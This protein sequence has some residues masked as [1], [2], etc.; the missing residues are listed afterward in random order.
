LGASQDTGG[1][2][3]AAAVGHLDEHPQLVEGKA[4]YVH[5]GNTI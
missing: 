5:V 3:E 2:Q 4:F 1:S